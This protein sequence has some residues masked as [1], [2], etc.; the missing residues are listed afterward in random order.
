[1]KRQEEPES[2]SSCILFHLGKIL[3]AQLNPQSAEKRFTRYAKSMMFTSSKMS[4]T[5]S[6]KCN[7]TPDPTP[8]MSLHQQAMKLSLSLSSQHTLAWTSMGALCAWI[9]SPRLS[10][11]EHDWDG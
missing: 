4:H 9:V 2:P 7:L 1:M 6:S 10:L 3:Q 8:Q 5:I 11:Q